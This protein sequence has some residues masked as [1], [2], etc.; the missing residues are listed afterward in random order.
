MKTRTE[1]IPPHKALKTIRRL[2]GD[3]VW[4]DIEEQCA[5]D[6]NKE[7]DMTLARWVL[8][9]MALEILADALDTRAELL[10]ALEDLTSEM[11]AGEW[12]GWPVWHKAL[13]AIE[14]AK[15]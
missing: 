12:E 9:E 7:A 3:A 1:K 8:S 2:L 13:A 5:G 6:T 4:P 10:D 11:N 15:A 14:K